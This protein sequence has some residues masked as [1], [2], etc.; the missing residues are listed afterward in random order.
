MYV[1]NLCAIWEIKK[2]VSHV[3]KVQTHNY[4]F[5]FYKPEASLRDR[6]TSLEDTSEDNIFHGAILGTQNLQGRPKVARGSSRIKKKGLNPTRH[7]CRIRN[8]LIYYSPWDRAWR[9]FLLSSMTS[10]EMRGRHHFWGCFLF[11]HGL[12]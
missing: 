3:Y 7:F 6:R 8:V 10:D 1:F 11:L 2:K 4:T 5:S 9:H 12:P